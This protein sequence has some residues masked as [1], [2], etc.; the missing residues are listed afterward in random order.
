MVELPRCECGCGRL[1]RS[2]RS[3]KRFYSP[4][5]RMRALRQREREQE[6]LNRQSEEF[7]R[8][9]I[10]L[11]ERYGAAAAGIRET[12]LE[13]AKTVEPDLADRVMRAVWVATILESQVIS[14]MFAEGETA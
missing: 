13:I 6:M 5:C 14:R 2:K 1:L 3:T 8:N 4:A 9:L 12:M 11:N 10:E 7:T